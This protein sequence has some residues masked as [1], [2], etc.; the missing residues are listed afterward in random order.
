MIKLI[1]FLFLFSLFSCEEDN[2]ANINSSFEQRE[3]LTSCS[4]YCKANGENFKPVDTGYNYLSFQN[5]GY[6][7]IGRC[8]GHAIVTQKMS[9]LAYFSIGTDCDLKDELCLNSY[10]E[11]IQKIMNFTPYHFKGFHNLYELSQIPELQRYLKGIVAGVSNRYQ[12]GR[13]IISID[14]Y[15]DEKLNTFYELERRVYAGEIPYIGVKGKLTGAHALLV[16]DTKSIDGRD[17]LCARDP[18]I[19]LGNAENCDSYFYHEQNSIFYK[20]LD[21]DADLMYKFSLTSDEDLRSKKY[22]DANKRY[23]IAMAKAKRLCH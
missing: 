8:R 6:R 23:C 19:V 3:E 22:K 13:A 18:N 5:F 15:E 14:R 21:R 2:K 4:Q 9:Q 20:R 10:K 7:G 11:G 1:L 16:Y 17:V 12:A